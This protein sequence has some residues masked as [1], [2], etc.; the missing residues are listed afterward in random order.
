MKFHEDI[1][2]NKRNI[3]VGVASGKKIM[4]KSVRFGLPAANCGNCDQHI[5]MGTV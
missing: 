5:A 1:I 4:V 2:I 3:S